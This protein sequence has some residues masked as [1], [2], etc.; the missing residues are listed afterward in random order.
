M[1]ARTVADRLPVDWHAQHARSSSV[2]R[3]VDRSKKNGRSERLTDRL[4][5]FLLD[6][7]D[8]PAGW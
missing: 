6:S 2:D 4:A 1:Q 8:W 7:V 5:I 3:P